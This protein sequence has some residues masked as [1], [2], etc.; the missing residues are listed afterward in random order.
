M[1]T[2]LRTAI[3]GAATMALVISTAAARPANGTSFRVA[4]GDTY[5]NLFGPDW[6]KAYRQNKVT[7]MRAGH[8]TSSPDILVEDAILTVTNDVELTQRA[9]SRVQAL[10]QRR[11]D[12][13]ARLVSLIPKLTDDP[14]AQQAAAECQR[15]LGNALRFAADVEFAE[16]EIAHLERLRGNPSSFRARVQP[17]LPV[18]WILAVVVAISALTGVMLWHR[19]QAVYPEGRA[20]CREAL[21]DVQAAF[22][23]E[24]IHL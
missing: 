5:I 15:V 16:H 13:Q 20:R 23:Q 24:G 7:V 22:Q 4:K 3:M 17:R 10:Q 6:E 12:L 21:K 8:P 11:S 14:G 9:W 2:R 1:T 19:Q 18:W